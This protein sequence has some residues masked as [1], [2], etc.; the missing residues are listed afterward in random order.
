MGIQ[1]SYCVFRIKKA[2]DEFRVFS[3]SALHDITI[4][5]GKMDLE[6]LPFDHFFSFFIFI[7]LKFFIEI[8]TEIFAQFE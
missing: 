1:S 3:C 5:L 4:N 2:F 6:V 7:T 8:I